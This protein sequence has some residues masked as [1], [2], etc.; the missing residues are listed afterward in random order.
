MAELR[1][2]MQFIFEGD[3]ETYRIA[4][5]HPVP[6]ELAYHVMHEVELRRDYPDISMVPV[7]RY[8]GVHLFCA[9]CEVRT[10]QVVRV[11]SKPGPRRIACVIYRV[12]FQE[13]SKP[14][15]VCVASGASKL[16]RKTKDQYTREGGRVAALQNALRH[17]INSDFRAAALRCYLGRKEAA[18]GGAA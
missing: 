17:D 9:E 12:N 2:N 8:W 4:F 11:S 13:N 1:R 5:Q 6:T 18:A 16:N 7:K 14:E 10:R 15:L 3:G